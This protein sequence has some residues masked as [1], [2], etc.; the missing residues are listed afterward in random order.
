MSNNPEISARLSGRYRLVLRNEKEGI[1]EDLEFD[2][3]ITSYGLWS[4]L[5]GYFKGYRID[6]GTGTTTPTFSDV[7]LANYI[8]Q[9]SSSGGV[10]P[11]S[12]INRTVLPYWAETSYLKTFNPGIG[13]GIITEVGLGNQYHSDRLLSR[14]LIKDANGNPTSITKLADDFL[15][16][17]YTVRSYIPNADIPF[18]A[19]IN[20]SAKT[21]FIRPLKLNDTTYRK[22]SA[23][24]SIPSGSSYLTGYA[25]TSPENLPA[26]HSDAD[27]SSVGRSTPSSSTHVDDTVNF[28]RRYTLTWN[29]D[30][31]N[32]NVKSILLSTY[33][34]TDIC[35]YGIQ[36]DEPIIKTNTQ[37]LSISFDLALTAN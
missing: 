12:A 8:A 3:L 33:W 29:P 32:I 17:F 36:F 6:I 5:Q 34:S 11:P 24:V 2:N 20:G 23:L 31:G 14:S 16:V 19:M 9:S 7:K 25:Y 15:D 1:K 35:P 18:T 27:V 22:W 30:K 21:G 10:I 13:T 37:R 28:K 26:M 4:I